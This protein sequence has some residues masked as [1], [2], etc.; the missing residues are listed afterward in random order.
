MEPHSLPTSAVIDVLT[1]VGGAI[2]LIAF[3]AFTSLGLLLPGL[4]TALGGP[5]PDQ[6]EAYPEFGPAAYPVISEP[7]PRGAAPAVPELG[8]RRRVARSHLWRHLSG[9]S[10]LRAAPAEFNGR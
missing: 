6:R 8:Q 3:I 7:A 4:L 9:F 5:A 1:V 10:V 2:A